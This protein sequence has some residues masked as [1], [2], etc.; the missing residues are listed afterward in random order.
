LGTR[1][2]GDPVDEL[3]ERGGTTGATKLIA[4]AIAD[5]AG[6]ERATP[7]GAVFGRIV[8]ARVLAAVAVL[9]AAAPTCLR[10]GEGVL[11]GA[12]IEDKIV[13]RNGSGAGLLCLLRGGFAELSTA[14]ACTATTWSAIVKGAS[15]ESSRGILMTGGGDLEMAAGSAGDK[16]GVFPRDSLVA[17]GDL[18][19]GFRE[20]LES[21]AS[22]HID[23]D[24][25]GMAV[26]PVC[27]L[28]ST[29]ARVGDNFWPVLAKC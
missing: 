12:A 22:V 27:C 21:V 18:I 11:R 16:G 17:I 8:E 28:L 7:K 10:V 19:A 20:T 24:A 29:F 13:V 14:R 3:A 25:A 4:T 2:L 9:G 5:A 26:E 6:V 23:T 1:A 15:R